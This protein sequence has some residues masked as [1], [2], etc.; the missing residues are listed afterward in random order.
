MEGFF[1]KRILLCFWLLTGRYHLKSGDL[2]IFSS[3]SNGEL[4]ELK[5]VLLFMA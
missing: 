2:E 5:E 3:K 1:N 4:T